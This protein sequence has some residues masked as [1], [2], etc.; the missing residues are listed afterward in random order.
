MDR[1]QDREKVDDI[2]LIG[3]KS[4][5]DAQ[6]TLDEP[7]HVYSVSDEQMNQ[8][9]T[10]LVKSFFPEFNSHFMAIGMLRKKDLFTDEKYSN[11]KEMLGGLNIVDKEDHKE[12][13]RRIKYSWDKNGKDQAALGT[14]MHKAI[15]CYYLKE[16]SEDTY[17]FKLF[18][19]F[20]SYTRSLG[21]IPFRTEQIV[22]DMDYSIAGSVDMMYIHEKDL[23]SHPKK[24][25]LVDWKRSKEIKTRAFGSGSNAYGKGP[26][27]HKA[28]CNFQHYSLQLNIYKFI[29]EKNYEIEVDKMSL[30]IFHPNQEEYLEY[31]VDSEQDIAKEVLESAK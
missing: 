23:G 31:E 10:Q 22:W 29:L 3:G 19:R 9:V 30:L 26:L 2:K 6:V 24:I 18:L 4:E 11:Y 28:N 25:W 14:L 15:E 12:A 13:V 20:D 8:S 16:T 27:N 5:R 7:T 17:E 21:Y 1:I